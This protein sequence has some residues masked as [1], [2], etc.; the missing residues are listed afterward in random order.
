[1]HRGHFDNYDAEGATVLT[2]YN[3]HD[4]CRCRMESS[5]VPGAVAG[6]TV[7]MMRVH[8]GATT[9]AIRTIFRDVAG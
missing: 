9:I 6:K 7:Y 8:D 2:E 5:A 3:P 1:M 4:R